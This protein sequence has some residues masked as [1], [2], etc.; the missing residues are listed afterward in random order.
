ME[1]R[2]H[3][4]ENSVRSLADALQKVSQDLSIRVLI[5]ELTIEQLL[6]QKSIDSQF[7]NRLRERLHEL[8]EVTSDVF[9]TDFDEKL[10]SAM[11]KFISAAELPPSRA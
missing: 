2:I 1:E 3:Y 5:Q 6:C 11:N 4:L 7:S 8:L 9:V 10:I